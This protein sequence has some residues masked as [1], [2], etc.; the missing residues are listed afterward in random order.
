MPLAGGSHVAALLRIQ[1]NLRHSRKLCSTWPCDVARGRN[2][3]CT[4]GF[5]LHGSRR[6]YCTVQHTDTSCEVSG[7]MLFQ[8]WSFAEV[9][10]RL[11]INCLDVLGKILSSDLE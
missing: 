4:E 9:I 6:L 10:H 2:V 5:L 8:W 7:R 3:A 1:C 11:V